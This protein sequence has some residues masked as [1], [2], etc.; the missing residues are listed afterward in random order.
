MTVQAFL[1]CFRRFTA[2]RSTP[3]L[4]VSDNAQAFKAASK[5]LRALMNDTQVKKYFCQQHTE[6]SFN[7][8]KAP[9]WGGFFEQLIGSLKRCLK[10]TIGRTKLFY[11]ELNTL[12]YVS[13]EDVQEP[14]TPAHF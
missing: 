5:E 3:L 13:S 7:L 1:R 2:R 4:V 14:L 9:W 10:K 12:S 8:E 11:E 6:W